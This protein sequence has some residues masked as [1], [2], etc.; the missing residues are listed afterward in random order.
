MSRS[1]SGSG[2]QDFILE[3]GSSNLLRDATSLTL[4]HNSNPIKFCNAH[5]L[6]NTVSRRSTLRRFIDI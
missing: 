4:S 3:T 5:T 6:W 1:S 2:R